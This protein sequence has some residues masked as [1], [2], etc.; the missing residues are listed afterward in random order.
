MKTKAGLLPFYLSLY[1]EHLPERRTPLEE[2][3]ST[4]AEELETRLV[5]TI[6]TE[7]CRTREEFSAAIRSF[8]KAQVDAI[9]TLHLAYSPSLESIDALTP[10]V[11]DLSI[12]I[13]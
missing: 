11:R 12:N 13:R 3:Y 6:T 8:E 4:I 10:R 2:F 1:D 7:I 9:I 5:T